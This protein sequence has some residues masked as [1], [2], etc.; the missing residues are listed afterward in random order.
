MNHAGI[1]WFLQV[2]Q[3]YSSQTFTAFA[4]HKLF[5]SNFSSSKEVC[6][7]PNFFDFYL[8]S[9]LAMRAQLFWGKAPLLHKKPHK[10]YTSY[11]LLNLFFLIII[12]LLFYRV[13]LHCMLFSPHLHQKALIWYLARQTVNNSCAH[14]EPGNAIKWWDLLFS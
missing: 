4:L 6:K 14:V 7:H 9:T 3:R 2:G 13:L 1:K 8:M 11:S 5:S 12:L 10:T